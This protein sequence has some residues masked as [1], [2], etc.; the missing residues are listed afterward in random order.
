MKSRRDILDPF[1]FLEFIT[2]HN[3]YY[4][5]IYMCFKLL[6]YIRG[7][8]INW[9]INTIDPFQDY[10]CIEEIFLFNDINI[11]ATIPH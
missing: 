4:A 7:G 8:S 5:T 1:S 10:T 6:S 9:I 11:R 2:L 3:I